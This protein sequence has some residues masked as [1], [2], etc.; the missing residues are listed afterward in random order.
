MLA[1]PAG[2]RHRQTTIVR[3]PIHGKSSWLASL[4]TSPH[5]DQPSQGCPAL[6][7]CSRNQS[8]DLRRDFHPDS[9]GTALIVDEASRQGPRS[10]EPYA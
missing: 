1:R 3:V 5:H 6:V 2:A 4:G 9:P 7:R 8:T 10:W